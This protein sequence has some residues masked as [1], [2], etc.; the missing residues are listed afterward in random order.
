M[1]L[2][3]ILKQIGCIKAKSDGMIMISSLRDENWVEM[4]S[5]YGYDRGE[6]IFPDGG[7]S[8]FFLVLPDGNIASADNVMCANGF[9]AVANELG[10]DADEVLG[11]EPYGEVTMYED[12]DG[13]EYE[14]T[15]IEIWTPE[16]FMQKIQLCQQLADTNNKVMESKNMNK[17]SLKITESE[18]KEMI[19]ES[20][21]K[22]VK[23][24]FLQESR[25]YVPNAVYIV[26]DGSS[27]YGVYGSDV[28]EEIDFN[29]VEVVKGPFAKWDDKV[30]ALIEKL[31]DEINGTELYR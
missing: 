13:I 3:N 20:V 25:S 18:L 22:I 15:V 7:H 1:D 6:L 4:F 24:S 11:S 14:D 12:E 26:C 27:C 17:T 29:D 16:E 10:F 31:N 19:I 9:Y 5:N 2:V 28:E 23:E 21:K 30:E 8:S